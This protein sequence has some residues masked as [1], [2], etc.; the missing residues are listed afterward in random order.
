MGTFS[1][2]EGKKSMGTFPS[3]ERVPSDIPVH[4]TENAAALLTVYSKGQCCNAN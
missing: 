2:M 1:S 4:G 3:R